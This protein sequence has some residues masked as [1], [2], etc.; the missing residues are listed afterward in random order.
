VYTNLVA[1]ITVDAVYTP[2]LLFISFRDPVENQEFYELSVPYGT[3]IS[4]AINA[5]TDENIKNTILNASN[6]DLPAENQSDRNENFRYGDRSINA[7]INSFATQSCDFSLIYDTK[8][9]LAFYLQ[10]GE[11]DGEEPEYVDTEIYERYAGDIIEEPSLKPRY[12]YIFEGWY[13]EPDGGYEL[14][15]NAP[16]EMDCYA[17]ARWTKLVCDISFPDIEGICFNYDGIIEDLDYGSD[18]SFT[19]TAEAGIE[20]LKIKANILEVIE[21]NGLYTLTTIEDDINIAVETATLSIY[22]LRFYGEN[23]ELLYIRSVTQGQLLGKEP[24]LPKRTGATGLWYN[25][26]TQY[27]FAVSEIN[28]NMEFKARYVFVDYVVS[29][30]LDDEIIFGN[31]TYGS[32]DFE[33]LSPDK[34][35]GVLFDGWFFDTELTQRATKDAVASLGGHADLYPKWT[36]EPETAISHSILGKW[37]GELILV[38]FLPNGVVRINEGQYFFECGFSIDETNVYIPGEDLNYN[39]SVVVLRGKTLEKTQK[40]YL[41]IQFTGTAI[42]MVEEGAVEATTETSESYWYYDE[43]LETPFEFGKVVDESFV[44]HSI[45]ILYSSDTRK[46][47]LNFNAM[48]GYTDGNVTSQTINVKKNETV[49]P[50]IVSATANTPGFFFVGWALEG[51]QTLVDIHY[52]NTFEVFTLNVYAVYASNEVYSGETLTGQ[53]STLRQNEIVFVEFFDHGSYQIL[54]IDLQTVS[55]RRSV[56]LFYSH[57]AQ[58]GFTDGEGRPIV[59]DE[60]A[61]TLTLFDETQSITLANHVLTFDSARYSLTEDETPHVLEFTQTGITLDGGDFSPV[62][63]NGGMYYYLKLYNGIEV[64]TALDITQWTPAEAPAFEFPT[65]YRGVYEGIY[66]YENEPL[67]FELTIND[68]YATWTFFEENIA[69]DRIEE[70]KYYMLDSIGMKFYYENGNY[71]LAPTQDEGEPIQ[72]TRLS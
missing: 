42:N 34:K 6:A 17:Y 47:T 43:E 45:L 36:P 66:I 67:T 1:D 39:G 63:Q 27:N 4:D 26:D 7:D 52:L 3:K 2:V 41:F 68:S 23:N 21:Q 32:T 9:Y 53:F 49:T 44:A 12:G 72:L 8:V 59:I 64:L 33:F 56:I 28:G 18:F 48:N 14:Y 5:L 69:L 19:V 20:I 57:S 15:F 13:S 61:A 35:D 40:N 65:D 11:L 70:E 62:F 22:T 46:V 38:E 16:L 25:G 55:L 10:G 50:S 58:N 24:S 29:Y 51:T 54:L 60:N 31:I 71:F 37:V 30:H